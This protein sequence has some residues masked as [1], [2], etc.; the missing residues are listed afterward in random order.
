MSNNIKK[1]DKGKFGQRVNCDDAFF[2]KKLIDER[3]WKDKGGSIV[4]FFTSLAIIYNNKIL[5]ETDIVFEVLEIKKDKKKVLKGVLSLRLKLDEDITYDKLIYNLSSELKN[6]CADSNLYGLLKKDMKFQQKDFHSLIKFCIFHYITDS[7]HSDK[8]LDRNMVKKIFSDGFSKTSIIILI[9]ESL[10]DEGINVEIHYNKNLYNDEEIIALYDGMRVIAEQVIN[11]RNIKLSEVEILSHKERE[12]ILK[13]FNNTKRDYINDK[14][15]KEVFEEIAEISGN[16]MAVIS[17]GIGLTYKELNER[18]NQL[19]NLLI[20]KGITKNDIVPIL[21]DKSIDTIVGILGV[22]KSGAAYLPIDEH[23][24]KSR[25]EYMIKDS[26]SKILLIR[27]NQI[28]TVASEDIK[29]EFI[30]INNEQIFKESKENLENISSPNDLLYVIYTSGSTGNPKGV[31]IEH[32]SAIKLVNNPNYIEIRKNDRVLQCGSLSFDTSVLQMWIALLNGIVIHLEDENLITDS[33][34]LKKYIDKNKITVMVIPTPLFHQYSKDSMEIFENLRW[35]MAGGDVL[36]GKEVSKL[37]SKYKNLKIVNGYGPTENTVISTCYEVK[38]EWDKNKPVPIGKPISNSTAYIMSKNSKLLPVGVAGELCVGGDGV[39]RGYL[40]KSEM[41][42]E[43]FIDNPYVKGE[44]IY[45]TGDLA[46]WLPDGNIEFIGRMDNQ[47]KIRGFRVELEEI[48]AQ[49][50]KNH[51][52]KEVAV[53]DKIDDSGNKYLCGYFVSDEKI[54]PKELKEFLKAQLPHYMIPSHMEQ[55]ERMPVNC[56]GKVDRKALTNIGT[57]QSNAEFIMP[58]NNMEEKLVSICGELFNIEKVSLKD[59]FLELGGDSLKV[60]NLISKIHKE[61][62]LKVTATEVFN[63]ATLEELA[64]YLNQMDRNFTDDKKIMEIEKVSEKDYYETSAVQKRMYAINQM[65]TK[66]ISYNVPI[67]YLIKGNFKKNDFQKAICELVNRHEALRTNFY[68]ID[69]NIVQKVRDNVDFKVNYVK[70]DKNFSDSKIDFSKFIK[71]FDISK[72]LLI[73]ATIIDFLDMSMVIIDMHHIIVDGVSVGII[74]KELSKLYNREKL[75]EVKIQYKDFSAWQN[76]LYYKGLLGEEENYWINE[77]KGEIPNLNLNFH[78]K[79]NLGKKSEGDTLNFEINKELTSIINK[80]LSSLGITKFMFYISAY[81]VLLYKYTGQHDLII[82]TPASGRIHDDFKETVGM[83]VNTLPIRSSIKENMSFREFLDEIKI[84]S[85]KAFENQNYDI[86]NLIEKININKVSLFDVIFSFQNMEIDNLNFENL[87]VCSYEIKTK[88]PKFNISLTLREKDEKVIGTIEYK[89]EL[90]TKEII[91]NFSKHY[92]NVLKNVIRDLDI[93][94]DK[95][96]ILSHK[97]KYEILYDFNNTKR[98]YPKNKTI[99]EIFEGIVETS[100]DKIAIFSTGKSISYRELNERSNQIARFLRR[101]GVKN[102]SIIPILCN[103]GIDTIIGIVSIIKSGGAYLPIDEDYPESRVKYMIEEVKSDLIL[104]KRDIYNKLDI[105]NIKLID[106]D[107]EE[108]MEESVENLQRINISDD[109]AY[110]IYTSGSTGIPKGVC[111]TQKNII[112]LVKNTNFIEFSDEDRILQTGSIAFDASTFEVWGA[113]L[114]GLQLYIEEKNIILNPWQLEEY[115]VKNKISICWFTAP[116]FSKLCEENIGLFRTLRY[117]LTGGD[118]V[119]SRDV[120]KVKRMYNELIIIDGYGPTENTTFSTTFSINNN[121]DEEVEIPIGK[122]IA[123]STAY[124]F[125]KDNNLLPMGIPGELCLGGDGI[126]SGYLNKPDLTKEKFIENPYVRGETIYRTGDLARWLPDGN[127]EFMGRVDNQVKINGF[128]I[129]LGEIEK[130]MLANINV[131]EATVIDIKDKNNNKCLCGYFVGETSLKEVREFLEKRI[132]NYMVPAYII[133]L[134][135]MPLNLNGKI[136][137]KALPLPELNK[138]NEKY[139][140]PKTENEEKISKVWME[141]L[142][143]NK[144]SI[145]SNFFEI[146]GNSLKAISVVSRLSKDFNIEINDLFKYSTIEELALNIKVE[147]KDFNIKPKEINS[148]VSD[149]AFNKDEKIPESLRRDYEEYLRTIEKYNKL[150]LNDI[151]Q[152]KNILL[153]GATGYLGINILKELIFTSD[154]KIYLLLRGENAKEAELKIKEK[155]DFYFGKELYPKY[156]HRINILVGDI[157]KEYLGLDISIY[158]QV[159]LEIDCIINS[160]ANVKHYGRYEDFYSVNVQGVKN[161]IEFAKKG[162]VKDFNQI[163]TMSVAHGTIPNKEL[164]MFSEDH[165][166]I[167]QESQ[168]IY[169]K[170]KLEA[171]KLVEEASKNSLNT[172]IFRV[173]NVTFNYETGLFQKNITENAFYKNIQAFIKLK[174]IPKLKGN[175]LDFCFVDQLAKAVILLFNK[176]NLKGEVFH[177]ENPKKISTSD[178]AKALNVKYKDIELKDVNEFLEH[179]SL[180]R[181]NKELIQYVDNIMVHFG[182][183]EEDYKTTFVTVN[184]RTNIILDK[185][186]FSWKSLDDSAVQRMLDYCEKV[187]FL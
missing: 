127:I 63:M 77:F 73:K 120:S 157:S 170:T 97:E 53:V 182:F 165:I 39:A 44:K 52:L 144:I 12:L 88:C 2:S 86:K 15:I 6:Y 23:Y 133:K 16:N 20:K 66:S 145:T 93:G 92:I 148:N 167:G 67:A 130:H 40:Y 158:E 119:S 132:P 137:K 176:C 33:E 42:K 41:T 64:E 129:E 57:K 17:N 51:K 185:L 5:D 89:T 58:K 171:E 179:I 85:L 183:F 135:D 106:Y 94:I 173:G 107:D 178:L 71:P 45:K 81:K 184:E 83:F 13:E 105:K 91:H 56:N 96:N 22:I 126:A 100:Q 154:S 150:D 4:E 8:D 60:I 30:D 14:S 128:R 27:S 95:I 162:L 141:I 115:M 131:K 32:R 104:G 160:A 108:I 139:L 186:G 175:T 180:M 116:L 102:N 143:L 47:V 54:L 161:L 155:A 74:E 10:K 140:A 156:R 34:E 169:V 1:Y 174:S 21:C 11:N 111:V 37:V 138:V 28:E 7:F 38:G 36:S 46:K 142:D 163:S 70:V 109:L 87:Q 125:S 187:K 134:K 65:D 112:R 152:Y 61:F 26:K 48:E 3:F 151:Q 18:A 9:K 101:R 78:N 149:E 118:V 146:G 164:A 25:I 79:K 181:E 68:V 168:N 136:D 29:A 153:T 80:K 124:I 76:K 59:N 84:K 110:V 75:H 24:P 117:L 172:K 114:N 98:E 123:N 55:L 90:F 166:Y 50:L 177:I 69:G 62:K 49:L 31:C 35:V 147:K 43:K 122:P 72:D 82:G 159:S 19:G 121:W 103:R 113:L 99:S